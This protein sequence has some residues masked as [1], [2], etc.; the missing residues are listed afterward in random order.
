MSMYVIAVTNLQGR[1]RYVGESIP[2]V[3]DLARAFRFDNETE[4]REFVEHSNTAVSNRVRAGWG[5]N[6]LPFG[7]SVPDL[8]AHG[9]NPHGC[10]VC[11]PI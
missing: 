8:C 6:V 9:K 2:W 10:L 7:G 11:N 1:M 5:A 4:A 3:D